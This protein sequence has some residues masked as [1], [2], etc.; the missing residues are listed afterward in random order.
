MTGKNQSDRAEAGTILKQEIKLRC[1]R[2]WRLKN[3]LVRELSHSF[4]LIFAV[5]TEE[6]TKVRKYQTEK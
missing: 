1:D 3:L 5:H 6:A 4:S 2:I